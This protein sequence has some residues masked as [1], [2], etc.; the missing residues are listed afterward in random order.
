MISDEVKQKLRAMYTNC[1]DAKADIP[2]GC[3]GIPEGC[4]SRND[5]ELFVT[6]RLDGD[7]GAK[8]ELAGL[9]PSYVSVGISH[10]PTMVRNSAKHFSETKIPN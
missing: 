9:A 6:F 2:K 8:F 7:N 4:V 5:C 3:F 10:D 1:G